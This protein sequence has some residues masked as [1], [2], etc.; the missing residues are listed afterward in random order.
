MTSVTFTYGITG[1]GLVT[2]TLTFE[3]P[4][5]FLET[6]DVELPY[7]ATVYF[8]GDDEEVRALKCGDVAGD[9][10]KIC[11]TAGCRRPSVALPHGNTTAWTTTA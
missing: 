11:P 5:A 8:V 6:R 4:L 10:T 1:E 9:L 7:D 3:S 2:E